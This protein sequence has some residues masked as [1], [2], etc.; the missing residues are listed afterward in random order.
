[1][2]VS[3]VGKDHQERPLE[4]L[5]QLGSEKDQVY[6]IFSCQAYVD[7]EAMFR[8]GQSART[9]SASPLTIRQSHRG[10]RGRARREAPRLLVI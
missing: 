7:D 6:G 4:A 9:P 1:M 10:R 5:Q 8:Q 3:Q 2:K